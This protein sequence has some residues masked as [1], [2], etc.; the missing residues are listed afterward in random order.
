MTPLIVQV[1]REHA[2]R[3]GISYPVP[4]D[5]YSYSEWP[6]KGEGFRY[7]KDRQDLARALYADVRIFS[8]TEIRDAVGYKSHTAV[9]A[10]CKGVQRPFDAPIGPR[11]QPRA[12]RSGDWPYRPRIEGMNE[13]MRKMVVG[14]R[15]WT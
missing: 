12:G 9:L 13:A 7:S 14:E 2:A 6:K 8:L 3:L 11:R 10:A 5:R 15:L 4:N 1:A